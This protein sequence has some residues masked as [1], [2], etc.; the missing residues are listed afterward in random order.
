MKILYVTPLV[1][2]FRD[3][4]EGK[5]E[6]KGL[7]SFVFPLKALLDDD[8]QVD[9][10]LVSN[11]V[12]PI[13][14]TAD[15]I[16]NEN[17]IAN[18][19]NDFATTRGL[20]RIRFKIRS[21]CELYRVINH[22]LKTG[23]YDFVY[24]HGTAAYL[25]NIIANKHHVRCGYRIYGVVNVAHDIRKMGVRKSII[26]YPLYYRIFKEK[27]EFILITDDGTDGDYAFEQ[28]NS[29]ASF[30]MYYLV[31]GVD[32]TF[33][34]EKPDDVL[35]ECDCLENNYIFHAGRVSRIK[36]QDR[37]I[38]VLHEL[39]LA[40]YRIHLIL[41]GHISD[42][43][44]YDELNKIVEQNG[45]SKYVHFIGAVER[46]E[47]QS[48]S[49]DA[50]ATI[51][52]GDSSNQGNIFFE[53]AFAGS[54]IITFPEPSLKKYINNEQSGFFVDDEK[55]AAEI[56]GSIMDNKYNTERIREALH[57]TVDS[58]LLTWDERVQS[59]I[60]LIYGGKK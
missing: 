31:N 23:N 56:V 15:W 2:G 30:P 60:E 35:K 19:N 48:L 12:K 13:N 37:V 20:Q 55:G 51:L 1:A 25:G 8:N 5:K 59:E 26:K 49:R 34:Y 57:N 43:P 16:R 17:I 28:F 46:T 4:L 38:K 3:L 33:T 36:R 9:I 10:V 53:C 44:Y 6:S 18:I 24:C 41:A 14:I 47:M 45:L 27:K 29:K 54:T 52:L 58:C 40:G 11:Y 7:P 39:H 50:V 32:K 22:T 42:E 21:L